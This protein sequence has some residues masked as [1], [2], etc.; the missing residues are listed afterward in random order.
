MGIEC[1][2][3][4]I[5][6]DCG[7]HI[8][9]LQRDIA[10]IQRE[11]SVVCKANEK[12]CPDP[13]VDCHVCKDFARQAVQAG[14]PGLVMCG[15]CA[16][17]FQAQ[18][19]KAQQQIAKAKEVVVPKIVELERLRAHVRQL[20]GITSENDIGHD[21]AAAE[22]HEAARQACHCSGL[23]CTAH[24]AQDELRRKRPKVVMITAAG[25]AQLSDL[26]RAQG[27][28]E[29]NGG[30][31]TIVPLYYNKTHDTIFQKGV[32]DEQ[33]VRH[34]HD[35][36]GYADELFVLNTDGKIDHVMAQDIEYAELCGKPIRWLV[37]P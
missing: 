10:D 29:I 17:E 31:L 25:D 4:G 5:C 24:L 9:D 22:L 37:K 15:N 16:L 35:S 1:K 32:V 23:R 11:H 26:A 6:T 14:V 8:S 19:A 28:E 20:E 36:I 12:P 13:L 30:H 7:E 21:L 34:R 3:Q 18:I 33:A 27:N 2:F